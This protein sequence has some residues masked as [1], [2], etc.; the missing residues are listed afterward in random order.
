MEGDI[1]IC[2]IEYHKKMIVRMKKIYV[3]QMDK[4]HW[5][6]RN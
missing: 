4:K 5:K 2:F 1:L 6:R 3:K